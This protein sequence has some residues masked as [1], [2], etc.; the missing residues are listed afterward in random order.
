MRQSCKSAEGSSESDF[1][2]LVG[3]W[4]T[5]RESIESGLLSILSGISEQ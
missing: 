5:L 2:F 1:Y 3:V 4:R